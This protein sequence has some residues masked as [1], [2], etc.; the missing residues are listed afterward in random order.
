MFIFFLSTWNFSMHFMTPSKVEPSSWA[1]KAIFKTESAV[2]LVQHGAKFS[3]V[4]RFICSIFITYTLTN[5]STI[6]S[7]PSMLNINEAVVALV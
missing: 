2:I 7:F 5:T 3:L 1:A 6:I 4:V